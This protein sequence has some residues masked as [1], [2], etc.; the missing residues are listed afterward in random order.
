MS[1][2]DELA[3]RRERLIA[4]AAEQRS[5]LSATV[6]QLVPSGGLADRALLLKRVV[7]AHPMWAAAAAALAGV[8]LM[9][10]RSAAVWLGRAWMMWR[11]WQAVQVWLRRPTPD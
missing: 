9:R 6:A 4:R 1:R 5:T 8:A 3:L 11:A 10:R 7:Q 2:L